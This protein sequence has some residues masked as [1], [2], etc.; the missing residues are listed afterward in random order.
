MWSDDTYQSEA[1]IDDS[2]VKIWKSE[3]DE[4]KRLIDQ[5]EARLAEIAAAEER[6][7]GIRMSQEKAQKKYEREVA[8]AERRKRQAEQQAKA[9]EGEMAQEITKRLIRNTAGQLDQRIRY[10][11]GHVSGAI[12]KVFADQLRALQACVEEQYLEPLNA[13]R[14]KREE[15][16]QLLVQ[17][18]AEIAQRRARLQQAGKDVADLLAL[19]QNALNS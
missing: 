11:E 10:L 19:T 9:V 17:G 3:R 13:K 16:Q 14:A 18:E 7:E 8:D 5:K 4:L 1:Y 6:K 15:L 12:E 2:N